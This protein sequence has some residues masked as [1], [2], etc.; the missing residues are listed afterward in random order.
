MLSHEEFPGTVVLINFGF[1]VAQG[2]RFPGVVGIAFQLPSMRGAR[3]FT[4]RALMHSPPSRKKAQ[5]CC[6]LQA[7]K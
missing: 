4:E 1:L 7:G 3:I 5:L 2:P 6:G